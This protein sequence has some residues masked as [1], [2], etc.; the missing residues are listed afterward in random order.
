[1]TKLAQFNEQFGAVEGWFALQSAALFDIFLTDQ[2]E[3]GV[4]GDMMEIGV[5]YGRSALLMA[6]H[7]QKGEKLWLNDINESLL[8]QVAPRI[9]EVAGSQA[10]LLFEPSKKLKPRDLPKPKSVRFHHI[11]GDHGRGAQHVDLAIADRIVSED[12]LVVLDDFPTLSFLG[13]MVGVLEWMAANPKSFRLFLAGSN[14]GYLCRPSR[15]KFYLTMI[16]DRMPKLLRERGEENFTFMQMAEA[17][18]FSGIGL[19]AR[20]WNRDFVDLTSDISKS[21]ADDRTKFHVGG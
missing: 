12:G 5:A 10:Q 16:R 8:K 18:D 13:L 7:A 11:D 21:D 14:K 15:E 19:T 2:A 3:R 20:Q 4:K 9:S 1:M 17:G 6:L